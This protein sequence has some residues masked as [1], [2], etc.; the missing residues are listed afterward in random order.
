MHIHGHTCCSQHRSGSADDSYADDDFT[1]EA[2]RERRVYA[3]H[4][5]AMS[6]GLFVVFGVVAAAVIKRLAGGRS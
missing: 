1:R 5:H 4:A 6:L 3:A 2:A